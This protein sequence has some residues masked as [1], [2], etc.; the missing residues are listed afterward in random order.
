MSKTVG[1]AEAKTHFLRLLDEVEGGEAVTVTRR[2]RPIA[3][4]VPVTAEK[5]RKSL[6]GLLAHPAYRYDD[7]DAP[8]YDRPWNA[9]L[10]ILD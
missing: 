8:A 9:E 7:P 5:P 3:R 2:G 10:G 6:L 4:I 1:A